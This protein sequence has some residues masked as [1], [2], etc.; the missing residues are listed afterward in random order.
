MCYY[1][2]LQYRS[3]STKQTP[4]NGDAALST[5]DAYGVVMNNDAY[6]VGLEQ[7]NESAYAQCHDYCD[8]AITAQ[9]RVEVQETST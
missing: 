8:I 9:G 6:A 7:S 5:N 3:R 2:R 4:G 1:Y